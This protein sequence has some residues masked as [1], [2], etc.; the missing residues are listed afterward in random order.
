MP[1]NYNDDVVAYVRKDYFGHPQLNQLPPP[2]SAWSIGTM[3]Q[4][5]ETIMH[6]AMNTQKAVF[7]LVLQWASSM[8][9]GKE[10]KKR[11][12][13]LI[14]SVQGFRHPYIPCRMF[15][16]NKFGGFVA[17]KYRAL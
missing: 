1:E 4:R 2:L 12:K 17:E 10:L 7:K 5:V 16:N 14:E 15:K 3:D 8:E 13:P 6:L 11:I 9:K